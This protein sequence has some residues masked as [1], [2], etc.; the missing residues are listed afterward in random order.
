M[1]AIQK[2]LLEQVADLHEV[3]QGAY[4]ES[5]ELFSYVD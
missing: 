4:I 3:P 2:R 5:G 1:D